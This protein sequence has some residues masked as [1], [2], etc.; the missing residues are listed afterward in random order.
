MSDD[1]SFVPKNNSSTRSKY[2]RSKFTPEEDKKLIELV[3]KYQNE[4]PDWVYISSKMIKRSLRQCRERWKNYLDPSLDHSEWNSEQDEQLMLKV[5][6]LGPSWNAIGRCFER[7]GNAVRNRYLV[8]SRKQ[9]K[10]KQE[11]TH[12]KEVSSLVE[13]NHHNHDEKA[14]EPDLFTGK[15]IDEI[16][17]QEILNFGKIN[18]FAEALPIDF[19][20]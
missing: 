20:F 8:L 5:D 2:G 17:I 11:N 16:D 12:H 1:D 9:M 18:S 19:Y 7:S 14:V 3:S 10:T 15:I 6:E 4:E 13:K